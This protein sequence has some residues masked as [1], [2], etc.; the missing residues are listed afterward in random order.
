MLLPYNRLMIWPCGRWNT[1]CVT[2]V[3]VWLWQMEWPLYCLADVIAMADGA[4]YTRWSHVRWTGKSL[5]SKKKLFCSREIRVPYKNSSFMNFPIPLKLSCESYKTIQW[6][7]PCE[8]SKQL[9]V[10]GYLWVAIAPFLPSKLLLIPRFGYRIHYPESKTV[11]WSPRW[12]SLSIAMCK[13][14]A[15]Y[16]TV[17]TVFPNYIVLCAWLNMKY[18]C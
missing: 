4:R 1:T 13:H 5:C 12:V 18:M 16:H 9:T 2:A 6:L 7:D 3:I 15:V 8:L 17:W 11:D 14:K 10:I